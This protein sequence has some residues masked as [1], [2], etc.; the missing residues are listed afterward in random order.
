VEEQSSKTV[1]KVVAL[2]AAL[3][4]A[5]VCGALLGGGGVYLLTEVL[6]DQDDHAGPRAVVVEGIRDR[7]EIWSFAGG[8][9]ILEV[10][11]DTPAD[12]T[13]LKAG[14][15]IVAV[16]DQE[17][18]FHA[19]LGELIASYEPGDW[20][21]LD[22]ERGNGEESE[23]RVRLG[24]HPENEDNAYLGVRYSAAPPLGMLERR[25]IPFGELERFDF[26]FEY[27][28]P[29]DL[30]EGKAI[31]GTRVVQV[32]EGG[33]AAIA[34]LQE[35]DVITALDGEGVA[36]PEELVRATRKLEAGTEVSVAVYRPRDGGLY[37]IEVVLG[38]HP[39]GSGRPYLGVEIRGYFRLQGGV[40]GDLPGELR[41]REP[42][43]PGELPHWIPPTWLP[44]EDADA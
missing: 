42:F 4:L 18:G 38:E 24:A 43:H 25:P 37:D 20:L 12:E 23:L 8:A 17:V 40:E 34:G 3:G 14:D 22:V 39:N 41:F 10:L 16:D 28:L 44:D 31:E 27:E 15:R 35:G 1:L 21:T 6:D 26:D 11:P 19:D 30:P 7:G 29:H 33:P 32:E 2:L 36:S 5:M 13:G 9:T